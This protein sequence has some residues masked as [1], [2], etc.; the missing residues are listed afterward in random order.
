MTKIC[1]PTSGLLS[2]VAIVAGHVQPKEFL[3]S[4]IGIVMCAGFAYI[5]YDIGRTVT[6]KN[7]WK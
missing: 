6:K 5:V 4:F 1:I 2:I 7:N 3:M